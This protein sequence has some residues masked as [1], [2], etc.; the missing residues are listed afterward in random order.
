[1]SN[2]NQD[3][4]IR[5]VRKALGHSA[6][7]K[8]SFRELFP[9]AF[10]E[11]QKKTL[12][13]IKS[14]PRE[15]RE[16]LLQKLIEQGRPLNVNVIP[17]ADNSSVTSAI[18]GLVEKTIPEWGTSKSLIAWKHPLIEA[19]NLP[20]EL[21]KQ[22]VPVYFTSMENGERDKT[23]KKEELEQIRKHVID[24]CIGVTSADFCLAETASLVMKTRPGQARSVSLVPSIHVAVIKLE[25]IISNLKELYTLLGWD[26]GQKEEG[27]TNCMTLITGPSKTG[28]IELV[29]VDGAHGPREL[30]LY[31]ITG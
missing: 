9:Q 25:Q 6:A 13:K 1:M 3:K 11:E 15:E 16:T 28:D 31:V 14:R 21:S 18:A 29:I 23:S 7:E 4:F 5:R 12:Q 30:Y 19:L 10:D 24:A 20:D 8:R 27:L 26:A 22:G 2:G 17:L